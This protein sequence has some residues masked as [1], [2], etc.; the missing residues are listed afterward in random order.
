[1]NKDLDGVIAEIW[2]DDR[3]ERRQEARFLI[4]FLANRIDEKKRRGDVASYVLNLDARW[5]QGKSF[6]LER[7]VKQ[8]VAEGYIVAHVNAWRDDHAED[9]LIAVLSSTADALKPYLSSATVRERFN[10]AKRNAGTVAFAVGKGVVGTLAQR[11][12]GQTVGDLIDQISDHDESVVETAASEGLSNGRAALT[13]LTD[14]ITDK[15]IASFHR[16]TGAID[17]FKANVTATIERASDEFDRKLPLFVVVDELD[18]CRPTY[19]VKMLERIK[20]M[21][22]TD[23][24][25]FLIATDTTQLR[26]SIRGTYGGD[27]DGMTYLQRFFDRTYVFRESDQGNFLQE[28]LEQ[29]DTQKMSFPT[30]ETIVF[31]RSFSS[32][33][34]LSLR[35]FKK[36]LEIV[37]NAVSAWSEPIKIEAMLL[38]PLAAT[39]VRQG[40]CS[41]EIPLA[42]SGW[43]ADED[44]FLGDEYRARSSNRRKY[45]LSTAYTL[46]TESLLVSVE[47]AT[48]IQRQDP[49]GRYVRDI[50]RIE[51]NSKETGAQQRAGSVQNLLPGLVKSAARLI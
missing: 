10:V 33:F 12:I 36:V 2:A 5:G 28:A 19:A 39:F 26:H 42:R 48:E 20:H 47:K 4:D 18:R 11:Y 50:A 16:E 17:G 40:D 29:I 7:F 38:F 34:S 9:P 44:V 45:S 23:N 41:F 1:L 35:E 25:V 51:F 37:E 22:E 13:K 15:L 3:L 31:L 46:L 30:K 32:H 14:E 6:F 21:F 24:V 27:F 8:L 49:E 43:Q